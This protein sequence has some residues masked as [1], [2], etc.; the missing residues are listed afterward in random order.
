MGVLSFYECVRG[1]KNVVIT[2][3]RG[4]YY[5]SYVPKYLE[6]FSIPCGDLYDEIVFSEGSEMV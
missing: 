4:V 3:M 2:N 1:R 5:F 6:Y